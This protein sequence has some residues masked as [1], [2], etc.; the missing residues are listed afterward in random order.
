METQTN[1]K[2][3]N[4]NRQPN[5]VVVEAE[6]RGDYILL[7]TF[8][9]GEQKTY[10]CKPLLDLGVFKRLKDPHVFNL[11][12]AQYGSVV[13]NDELDIAPEELYENGIA[14]GA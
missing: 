5:W 13:W 11:A 8:V 4:R 6:P 2:T 7:V 14:V 3:I 10:D 9:T 1:R 12:H